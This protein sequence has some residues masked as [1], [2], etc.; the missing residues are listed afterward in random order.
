LRLVSELEI[1]PEVAELCL[2]ACWL[3]HAANAQQQSAAT[4]DG[5]FVEIVAELAASVAAWPSSSG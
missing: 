5:S 2:H 1:A 4:R 3:R